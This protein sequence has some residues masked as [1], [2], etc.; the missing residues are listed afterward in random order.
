MSAPIQPPSPTVAS[1]A[2]IGAGPRGV[3]VL[4]RLA[5]NLGELW[6]AGNPLVVHL[7]DPH[8]AGPGRI[9]RHDQSPLLKL[10][11][12]A[13]D[14]TMFTDE[15]STI[16]GPVRPGPSLVEWA[17]LVRRGDVRLPEQEGDEGGLDDVLR[18]E[19]RHL[20]PA[21]FPTR[22]L[23]SLYLRWFFDE[24]VALLG[25]EVRVQEHR[26]M[27]RAV[28]DASDGRQTVELD[29]GTELT[30][31]L[32]LYSLGHT[33]ADPE[34]EHARL[35]D[36]ASRRDLY[37]LPPAFT[38]DADTRPI[39]PGQ[40]VIVRGF[41]LAAVD[42]IVLLTEG[43]GGR[44]EQTESDAGSARLRYV[45]S[46]RE[47]RIAVGSRRG[48]P[49]HSKIGSRLV[50]DP[51][52][53]RF[54]TAEA[55]ARLEAES[56]SLDFAADIWPLIAKEM[57]WGYY[58]EL[59]TGHPDRV[60]LPWT[61]FAERFE[62]IDARAAIVATASA[63][64]DSSTR[65]AT[66]G[67]PAT[68]SR[69]AARTTGHPLPVEGSA[70]EHARVRADAASLTALIESSVPDEL[71][72][73]FLPELDRPLDGAR[74]E[75]VEELQEATR[76][77]I[78]RDLRLR[79][80][81]EHSATLGLFMSILTAMFVFAD[82][83]ASPKWS[84]RSRVADLN[85]WWLGY[86]SFIASGP[87]AHRL[88]ELLALS[89]AGIVEFIGGEMWVDADEEHGTFHAGSANHDRVVSA[90]AL[91]DA[92]LPD[93]SV[94][95]SDNELLRVLLDSG[96]ALEEIARDPGAAGPDGPRGL[97][98][99]AGPAGFAA[100]TGRLTVRPDDRR[101]V[102][103]T[104]SPAE[105]HYAIGP[106]TNSPFVGAFSRPQTNAV[107]FREN[108]RVARALLTHL[109]ALEAERVPP[110]QP[111]E[112]IRPGMFS[113]RLWFEFAAVPRG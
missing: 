21:S 22:R 11:S 28:S 86:F 56:E 92:R 78:E 82:L 69:R 29:D 20:G 23:Q 51:P 12:M 87:P 81:P 57:L 107:S 37:Y 13:A 73:L 105:R 110:P 16:E 101:V 97:A 106:Y 100:S 2:V 76:A 71:D 10:N 111:P 41:G 34:P 50:G 94:A 103:G 85:G 45:P 1:V 44:F 93:T 7:V 88:D 47:P 30:V 102:Q 17:D 52:T 98:D 6:T 104:G 36:F 15:R 59:F 31:D 54:F 63:R 33:G 18:E 89:E 55:A 9:W 53:L 43:R 77:Y 113:D 5:A 112:S 62:A 60:S 42:L 40:R 49:Y 35:I 8:P 66:P 26:T 90:S 65:Q 19:L 61:E 108:D 83:I 80:L 24:A 48:V 68:G 72:R 79:T 39:G 38:A 95:R 25:D 46:G 4:E 75:T 14:V 67:R 91:V 70:E 96:Q 109:A 99:P 58:R 3:G 84:A 74:F 27:A 64:P 32:V